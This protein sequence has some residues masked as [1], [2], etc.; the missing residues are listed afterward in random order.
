MYCDETFKKNYFEDTIKYIVNPYCTFHIYSYPVLD[1]DKY[2]S[3]SYINPSGM[4]KETQ[5]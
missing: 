2:G 3:F 1:Y 4:A 5:L